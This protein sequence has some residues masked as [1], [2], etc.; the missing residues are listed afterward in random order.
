MND[1]G[2]LE[3][4]EASL[5]SGM[6]RLGQVALEATQEFFNWNERKP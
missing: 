5:C 2:R 3:K 1:M 6:K 4:A